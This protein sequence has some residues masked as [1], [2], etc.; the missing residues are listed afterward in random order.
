MLTLSLVLA[1]LQPPAVNPASAPGAASSPGPN[2]AIRFGRPDPIP[3]ADGAFRICSYN[4]ENLFDDQDDPNL[5]GRYEDKDMLKPEAHRK[6]AAEAIRRINADVLCLQE[7]ES[8]QAVL[9]FRDQFLTDMGY[10]YVVSKD[11]GDERGIEQAVLS[12]YPI[13]DV[14]QWIKA[15]LG[16]VHPDKWGK[17]PNENAGKPIEYHRS[18]LC[19]TVKVSGIAPPLPASEKPSVTP[20]FKPT[21]PYTLTLFVVHQ[22]SGGKEGEYWREKEAAKTSELAKAMQAEDP[23]RNIVILGDFNAMLSASSMKIYTGAGFEDAFRDFKAKDPAA[24]THESGRIIDHV[25]L[26][27]AAAKELVPQTR[28]VLG[29]P[30]RPEGADWRTTPPPEGYA[31]DHYPVVVDLMATDR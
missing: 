30:A 14:Q 19:V 10:T 6:A 1:L 15:P 2:P 4:I 3:K 7:V 29:M 24:I 13:S 25:F 12:R 8:E 20:A 17:N 9:W 18:P 26:N 22:K 21:E 16:G 27:A 31:G 23:N 5:S 28:F 11:A